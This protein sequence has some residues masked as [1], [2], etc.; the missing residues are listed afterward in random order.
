MVPLHVSTHTWRKCPQIIIIRERKKM[1][2]DKMHPIVWI[3][4]QEGWPCTL[5]WIDLVNQWR[6][7][8]SL[9][10]TIQRKTIRKGDEPLMAWELSPKALSF[11]SQVI[12]IYTNEFKRRNFCGYENFTL[13]RFQLMPKPCLGI[14]MAGALKMKV[15][16]FV[17][18]P[19]AAAREGHLF[20]R[21]F[22]V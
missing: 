20:W 11:W 5:L 21:M 22:S 8:T 12:S 6:K 17:K 13:G 10:N 3:Y 9:I 2:Q 15:D 14:C 18:S 4:H 7:W 1:T 16:C 19:I